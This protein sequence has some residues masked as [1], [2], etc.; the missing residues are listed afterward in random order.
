MM[1]SE[2]VTQS[3]RAPGKARSMGEADPIIGL[4]NRL[5]YSQQRSMCL[6]IPDFIEVT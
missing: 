4:M 1:N 5:G 2:E 6:Y 3:G